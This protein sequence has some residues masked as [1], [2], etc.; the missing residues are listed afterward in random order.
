MLINTYKIPI[1]TDNNWNKEKPAMTYSPIRMSYIKKLESDI[2]IKG[3]ALK[4]VLQGKESYRVGEEKIELGSQQYLIT[5]EYQPCFVKIDRQE[6]SKGI[7]IDIRRAFV[8]DILFNLNF[9]NQDC[10]PEKIDKFLFSEDCF[11]SGFTSSIDLNKILHRVSILAQKKEDILFSEE[12]LKDIT[13]RLLLDQKAFI[14]NYYRLDMVKSTT[15]KE[16]FRRLESARE[17]LHDCITN[18]EIDFRQLG[19]QVGLSE[20]R[21]HHLF[22]QAYQCSPYQY[23]LTRKIEKSVELYL[24]NK[25]SWTEIAYY[26]GFADIASFSKVFKKI[27]GSSPSAFVSRLQ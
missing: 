27:K 9:P 26:L 11:I 13:L 10:E 3:I 18:D 16:N 1:L 8:K 24:K 2:N 19:R 6:E 4:Y 22:K 14:R 23:Y 25:K 7:C 21:L 15:R 12:I 5:N 17:I 20:F